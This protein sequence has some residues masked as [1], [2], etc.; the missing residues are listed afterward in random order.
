[1]TNTQSIGLEL[2]LENDNTLKIRHL[3]KYYPNL[4]QYILLSFYKRILNI[5]CNYMSNLSKQII[6]D[7]EETFENRSAYE[8]VQV[9]LGAS[10]DAFVNHIHSVLSGFLTP[11]DRKE[12]LDDAN[13]KLNTLIENKEVILLEL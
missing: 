4:Y 11:S 5:D 10:D 7:D 1:M 2:D 8:C 9:A 6:T 13:E 3:K 12:G